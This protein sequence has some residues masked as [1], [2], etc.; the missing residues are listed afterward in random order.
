MV[1]ED[2]F[3]AI[4]GCVL[5]LRKFNNLRNRY[6]AAYLKWRDNRWMNIAGIEP[7]IESLEE[8]RNNCNIASLSGG[9]AGLV[10][11]IL[12]GAGLITIPFTGKICSHSS[13]SR[14][15]E[16]CMRANMGYNS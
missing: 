5:A 3:D 16:I 8:T 11:G 10:G 15:N 4:P 6:K 2:K 9:C 1:N 12:T 14:R 13:F 7:M